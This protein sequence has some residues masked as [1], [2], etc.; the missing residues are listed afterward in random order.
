M[1]TVFSIDSKE[2]DKSE[3]ISRPDDDEDLDEDEE[4]TIKPEGHL[5]FKSK[6][7]DK[8]IRM[9]SFEP[10]AVFNKVLGIRALIL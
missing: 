7:F 10:D 1:R 4:Y 5:F 2:I 6:H 8:L 9:N 3:Y